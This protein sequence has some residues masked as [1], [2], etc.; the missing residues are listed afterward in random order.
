[1]NWKPKSAFPCSF[2]GKGPGD[3]EFVIVGPAIDG[4]Q[5]IACICFECVEQCDVVMADQRRKVGDAFFLGRHSISN[6]RLTGR[7]VN[8][9]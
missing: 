6:P 5:A 3:V 1:M 7:G 8:S 2:C 4:T 9:T